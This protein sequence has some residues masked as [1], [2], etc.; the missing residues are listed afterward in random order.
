MESLI[1]S[2]NALYPLSPPLEQHLRAILQYDEWAAK[3]LLLRAGHVCERIGFIE[4]GLLRCYYKEGWQEVTAWFMKEGDTVISVKS[5]FRQCPG[6]EYIQ[7]LEPTAIWSITYQQL[8][9]CYQLYPE[10]NTI[11]R[12]LTEQYYMLSEDRLY[13]MRRKRAADR[14]AFMQHHF[15]DLLT[16][17]PVTAMASYLGIA[18][19]TLSRVRSATL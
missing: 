11:G 12:I 6:H 3:K 1:K 13:A 10:F 7:A 14:F 19:E 17:V 9:H 15:P 5:F 16:R 18:Q 8:Q 2:L 4:S